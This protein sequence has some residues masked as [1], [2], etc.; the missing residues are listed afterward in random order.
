MPDE[1]STPTKQTTADAR[2]ACWAAFGTGLTTIIAFGIALAT[3]PLSGPLCA[4]GCFSYPYHNVAARFPR[5]YYWMFPA[6]GATLMYVAFML[7]L[8]ARARP[9]RRLVAQFALALSVMAALTIVGDYFVQLAVVQPSLLAGETDGVSLLIQYNPHG[10]FIALEELGYLLMSASLAAMALSL[11]SDT[12]MERVVRRLFGSGF[13]VCVAALVWLLLRYGHERA[14]LLEVALISIVWL[15]L[16][17]GTLVMAIV[18]WP[19]PGSSP[20][21]PSAISPS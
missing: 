9:E 7:G 5:D 15:T 4:A 20:R 3:P 19:R 11:S 10:V 6:M 14:Y 8:H 17:P 21:P 2:F 12:R 13:V 16:I 1:S 18:L